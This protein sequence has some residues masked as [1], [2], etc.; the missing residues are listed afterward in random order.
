MN[1]FFPNPFLSPLQGDGQAAPHGNMQGNFGT[2]P[3]SYDQHSGG[4]AQGYGPSSQAVPGHYPS[5]T[6][7]GNGHGAT[8]PSS[9]ARH[10]DLNGYDS[11]G[12]G[13]AMPNTMTPTWGYQ[14]PPQM[15][16]DYGQTLPPCTDGSYN[17]C[18]MGMT[19][20]GYNNVH[21]GQH[22]PIYPWMS[23]VGG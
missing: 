7:P 4:P 20:P 15:T 5:T 22:I 8:D 14:G 17:P 21:A 2:L 6:P 13:A 16:S 12:Q 1:S 9:C 18:S 23:V 11:H 19:P 10:P 3:R